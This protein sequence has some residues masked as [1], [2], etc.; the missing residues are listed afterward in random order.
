MSDQTGFIGIQ[1]D[2]AAGLDEVSGIF[3]QKALVAILEK[4][5]DNGIL[6]VED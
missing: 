6:A 1:V 4:M 5:A 3:N 2:V